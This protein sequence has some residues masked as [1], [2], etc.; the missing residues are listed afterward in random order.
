MGFEMD[1]RELDDRETSVL[2]RVTQWWKENR[3]WMRS[4]DILRLVSA[5][6]SVIAEQQL[7]HAG[8]QFVVFAGQAMTSSQICPR[9][10]RLTAL[11]PKAMYEVSLANRDEITNLSR[12]NCALKD[13][14]LALSGTYLMRHGITLPWS[15]PE[16]MWVVE[17]KRL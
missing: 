7:H 17:G 13:K 12:G 6:P 16:R 15:F 8:E 4:A 2:K 1:P 3:D 11:D 10:L 9:P 14:D 5:D